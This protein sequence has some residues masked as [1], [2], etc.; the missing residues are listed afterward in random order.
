M[1]EEI[2]W[3]EVVVKLNKLL[4]LKST[5]VALKYCKA[6][7]E[8]DEIPK[9]RYSDKHF[10]PCMM[11][12]QAIYNSWTVG[13]K[14]EN[15]HADYCRTIH[16][17]FDRDE[18]FESGKMFLGG[19]CGNDETAQKHHAAL[20]LPG[21]QFVGLAISPL[22]T[23]RIKQPDVCLIYMTPGQLFMFLSGYLY[24]QYEVMDFTFVGESSCNDS[25]VKTLLTG[26]PGVS[27]PCFAERK[28]GGIQDDEMAVS[29]T[30]EDL[31][32]SIDGLEKLSKNGLRYPIPPYSI[33]NDMLDGL[34]KH[35]SDY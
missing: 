13:L 25:W 16:G 17:F 1:S 19:W 2:N 5:P 15:F 10:S 23:G 29:M 30:P 26:K 20:K 34:P 27:I 33:S 31:L 6:Q 22:T 21:K 12:G 9:I 28:F 14:T 32:R 8:L 11:I 3:S 7:E 18:R 35:Y 24:E 4:R